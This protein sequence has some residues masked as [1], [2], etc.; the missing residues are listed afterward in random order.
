MTDNAIFAWNGMMFRGQRNQ[1]TMPSPATSAHRRVAERSPVMHAATQPEHPILDQ[2]RVL[3]GATRW[4]AA[5]VCV[6]VSHRWSP[7]PWSRWAYGWD[8]E[9]TCLRC[10]Q[11][12]HERARLH[13][14]RPSEDDH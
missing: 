2:A 5:P 7:T 12:R 10:G 6:L 3:C 1:P 11:T 9:T 4:Y 13:A 14:D 8:R